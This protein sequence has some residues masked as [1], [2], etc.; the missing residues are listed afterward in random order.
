LRHHPRPY[1]PYSAAGEGVEA[2]G[3]AG[4][5]SGA[6]N[7]EPQRPKGKKPHKGMYTKLSDRIEYMAKEIVDISYCIHKA[8]GHGLL[9]SVYEKCFAYELQSRGISYVQQK[10]VPIKY[11][12]FEI[13]D[14]LRLDLLVDD[15]IIIE[16]KAQ[17]NYH[18][19]WDAQ[20]L[21]YLKL[22]HKPLG[23]LINFHVP[24]IRDGIKRMIN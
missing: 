16:L 9:E 1:P 3:S 17:E 18:P 12:D 21:N 7:Y 24:L 4:G 19:V 13:G 11:G 14:G 15:T 2:E 22:T 20:L 10:M 23:F 5:G 8:I 6:L